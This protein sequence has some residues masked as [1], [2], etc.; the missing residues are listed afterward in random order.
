MVGFACTLLLSVLTVVVAAVEITHE[1]VLEVLVGVFLAG[2]VLIWTLLITMLDRQ[3]RRLDEHT[4]RLEAAN[5]DLDAFA[6]RVAH[7][8]K[9]AL[10]PVTLAPNLLR[11]YADDPARVRQFADRIDRMSRKAVALLDALLAFSRAAGVQAHEAERLAPAVSGVVDELGPEIA[12]LGVTFDVGAI[13]DLTVRCSAGLLHIV[14]ANL[15]GNAVKFLEGAPVR[16][17]ELSARREGKFCRID[18]DDTGPG[19]P[20][21]AQEKIFE[22]FYRVEGNRAPGTGIGLATVRRVVEQ[23][24]GC[25][26]VESTEGHGARFQVWPVTRSTKVSR[27]GGWP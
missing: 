26:S 6:G 22:P 17:V 7:D 20:R 15:C 16:R 11:S 12:R 3:R 14:L 21:A 4:G 2:E 10:T 19:I 8:L 13:P 18:V 27:R 23:R 24:G 5:A 1:R 25:I 9:N